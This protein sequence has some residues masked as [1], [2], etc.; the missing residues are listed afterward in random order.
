VTSAVS[1]G[2]C[3]CRRLLVCRSLCRREKIVLK[4][5]KQW[6]ISG[7]C[8]VNDAWNASRVPA[9]VRSE[10]ILLTRVPQLDHDVVL[11]ALYVVRHKGNLHI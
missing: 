1:E 3:V 9:R 7:K 5:Y 2:E 11:V 4:W 6:S 10:H 8:R